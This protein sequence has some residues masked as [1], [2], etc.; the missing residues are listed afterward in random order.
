[1]VLFGMS[2]GE[3]RMT[4]IKKSSDLVNYNSEVGEAYHVSKN[5]VLT[6]NVDDENFKDEFLNQLRRIRSKRERQRSLLEKQ[7][8]SAKKHEEA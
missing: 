7:R 4:D 6:V 8:Q 1:M 3:N 2:W 5:G